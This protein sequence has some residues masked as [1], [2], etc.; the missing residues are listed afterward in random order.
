[1]GRRELTVAE[2]EN[3]PVR[4]RELGALLRALRIDA[5]M[6]VEEVAE[7]LLCSSTK[8]S[9]METGQRSASQRDVRDLCRIYGV[10]D[11]VHYDHLMSLARQGRG[12]A[13]WQ[14]YNLPYATYVGLEAEA[15]TIRDYESGV[16]P[17][18]F[19]VPDYV[20]AVHE[21]AVHPLSSQVIDQRIEERIERQK[22]LTSASPPSVHAILDE[23]VLHRQIGGPAVMARQLDRT[24]ELAAKLPNVTVQ[25]LPF[26]LG[27]HPGLDSTFIVLGMVPPVPSVVYVEGLVGSIYLERDQD[28]SRYQQ[29]FERLSD[30]SL[31]QDASI[32]LLGKTRAQ[33]QA[34]AGG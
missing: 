19:Q 4:R 27:A 30:I 8:I 1:M 15:A 24:I 11:Q 9:R 3:P 34:E 23:A 31:D 2:V 18:L 5:G 13:W 28:V 22:I 16:F 21:G 26:R 12:Q 25:V 10:T 33:F 32:D 29:I 17:G 20:R 6:T 14:P 7:Q